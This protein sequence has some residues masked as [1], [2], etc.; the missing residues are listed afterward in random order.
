MTWLIYRDARVS[1]LNG[2]TCTKHLGILFQILFLDMGFIN[3][4]LGSQCHLG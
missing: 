4:L 2:D 1:E 3:P